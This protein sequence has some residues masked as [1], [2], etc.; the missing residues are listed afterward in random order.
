MPRL[1]SAFLKNELVR[2]F[3]FES[4][5]NIPVH[6]DV[7]LCYT[8]TERLTDEEQKQS[9]RVIGT[10]RF[11]DF[12]DIEARQKAYDRLTAWVLASTIRKIDRLTM[13]KID[14]LVGLDN[15]TEHDL[16]K[17]FSLDPSNKSPLSEDELASFSK[18]DEMRDVKSVGDLD[19]MSIIDLIS[20]CQ[21]FRAWLT[22]VVSDISYFTDKN[23]GDRRKN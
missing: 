2:T 7:T 11:S 22:A 5:T 19:R 23:E 10:R 16:D 12:E 21:R 13:R 17:E 9:R 15:T 18:D 3:V 1:G 4:G 6:F 20:K 14:L 8:P